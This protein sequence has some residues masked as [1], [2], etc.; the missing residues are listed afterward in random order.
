MKVQAGKTKTE[1]AYLTIYK[2]LRTAIEEGL[3]P[4]GSRL[5]SKRT[6][7]EESGVSVVTVEHAYALLEDEGYIEAR[8]RSGYF[9]IYRKDYVFPVAGKDMPGEA[10]EQKAE[11]PESA[12]NVSPDSLPPFP[13]TTYAKTMR[14]VLTDLGEQILVKGD[15]QGIPEL[16]EEIAAYLARSRG[17]T[18]SPDQIVVG[19]GA[20]YLYSL[21]VQ[22]LGREEVYGL[23]NPSYEKIRRVYEANGASCRLLTMG[24]DGIL[25]DALRSTDAYVLHVTP[26]HSYPSGVTATASKRQEYLQWALHRSAV[27]V[28]DDFDSEFSLQNKAVDTLFS[29]EPDRSVI[30]INTFSRS[31]APSMRLGYM[32]LPKERTEEFFEKIRFYSCTVPVFEQY[33]LAEFIRSGDFERHINRVRRHIRRQL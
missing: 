10:A 28:E 21:V 29:Q 17:I 31:I 16:R 27:I 19:A 23:E 32:V 5:P 30:Y 15:N 6:Q 1:T 12:V 26:F 25:S 13:F 7:A 3:Y 33:V 2:L 24:S 4:C 8:Q 20:E 18:V 11:A 9:V 22:I 14:K